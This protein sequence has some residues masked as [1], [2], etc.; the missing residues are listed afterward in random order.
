MRPAARASSG[1]RIMYSSR[2]DS[3]IGADLER[4]QRSVEHARQVVDEVADHLVGRRAGPDDDASAYLGD[5]HAACPQ[6][7]SGLLARNQVFRLGIRRHEAAHLDDA[8]DARI[9][10]S[11]GDFALR[12]ARAGP[13]RRV[14]ARGCCRCSHWH[15]TPGQAG[16]ARGGGSACGAGAWTKQGTES[17]TAP[18]PPARGWPIPARPVPCPRREDRL[19]PRPVAGCAVRPG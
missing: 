1:T 6:P 19:R 16:A 15:R 3:A 4:T 7:V 9:R 2:L 18:L 5:R 14:P 10:R 11:V 12:P 13:G 17:V 8:P